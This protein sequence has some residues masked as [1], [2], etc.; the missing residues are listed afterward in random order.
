MKTE[1]AGRVLGMYVD[2]SRHG[3]ASCRVC[4]VIAR[5]DGSLTMTR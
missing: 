3:I 4:L 2:M 1:S 5:T